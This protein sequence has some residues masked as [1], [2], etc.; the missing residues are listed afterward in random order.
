MILKFHTG[1]VLYVILTKSKNGKWRKQKKRYRTYLCFES[2]IYKGAW[3]L[4]V[5]VLDEG[6]MDNWFHKPIWFK[7]FRFWFRK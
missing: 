1:T 3:N 6:Y 7:S 4:S 2:S 5:H